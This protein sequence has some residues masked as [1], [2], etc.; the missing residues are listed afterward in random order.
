MDFEVL[1]DYR[2]IKN[3]PN[4]FNASTRIDYQIPAKGT[5]KMVIHDLMGRIVKEIVIQNQLPGQSFIIWDGKDQFG[6]VVG[7]GIYLYQLIFNGRIMGKN[8]MIL[9]K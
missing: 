4:P 7:S 3:Y 1:D 9:L 5:V 6:T 8:K 2:L